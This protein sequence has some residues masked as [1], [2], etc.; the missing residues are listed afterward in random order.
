M[1]SDDETNPVTA[2][3]SST[4]AGPTANPIVSPAVQTPV[5]EPARCWPV[6]AASTAMVSGSI[7]SGN[8]CMPA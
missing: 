6:V 8:I 2:S 1:P 3:M 7:A 5:N 4:S